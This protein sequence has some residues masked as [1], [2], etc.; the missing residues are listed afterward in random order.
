[1]EG[2]M[3]NSKSAYTAG[4]QNLPGNEEG[5]LL[6]FILMGLIIAG[7]TI[8]IVLYSGMLRFTL[9]FLILVVIGSNLIY[10]LMENTEK[11]T[12]WRRE[13]EFDKRVNLQLKDNSDLVRRAFKDMELSQGYLEKKIKDLFLSKLADKRNLSKEEIRELQQDPERFRQIV[14]D[15]MISDFILYKR[16]G[17]NNG[18]KEKIVSGEELEGEDYEEWIFEI[19]D[20]IQRWE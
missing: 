2:S 17:E 20:R 5:D 9:T 19:I 3:D 14:N 13:G 6:Y 1:M 4:S 18:E 16:S 8:G 10:W 7:L 15:E 12:I 11:S